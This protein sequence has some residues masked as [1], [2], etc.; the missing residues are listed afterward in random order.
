MGLRRGTARGIDSIDMAAFYVLS[1]G[2]S[3]VSN[4]CPD[5]IGATRGAA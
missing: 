2:L 5:S 3:R 1:M 4:A